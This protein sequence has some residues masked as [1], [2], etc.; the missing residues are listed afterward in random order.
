MSK[1]TTS[2]NLVHNEINDQKATGGGG[3]GRTSDVCFV[4]R[5]RNTEIKLEHGPA[6]SR[7]KVGA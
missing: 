5:G 7:D 6:R 3:G 4:I 1:K 2:V